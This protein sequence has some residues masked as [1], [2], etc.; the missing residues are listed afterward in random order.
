MILGDPRSNRS[1]LRLLAGRVVTNVGDSLYHIAAMWLIF[2]LTGSPLYTGIGGFL[3]TAPKALTFLTGP[4]VDRWPLRRVLVGTQLING[5]LVLAIPAAAWTGHLSV[6]IVLAAF[7]LVTFVNQFVYPAQNAAL[8]HIVEDDD[9]ARA[10][11]L[12]SAAYRGADM[13]FSAASGVL[14]AV[15]G[16][17]ALFLVDSVTFFVA[18]LLFAGLAVTAG[19]ED[20]TDPNQAAET[21]DQAAEATSRV[22]AEGATGDATRGEGDVTGDATRSDGYLAELREGFAYVRGSLLVGLLAGVVVGNVTAGAMFGVLPAF[23]AT[24]GGPDA[25]G[26][27]MAAFAGGSLVGTLAASRLSHLPFGRFVA[28]SNV[29]SGVLFAAVLALGWFPAIVGALFLSFVPAG[30]FTVLFWTMLQ[31]TVGEDLLGRVSSL[32]TSITTIAIPVGSAVGG[33]VA[34]V[35]GSRIVMFAWAAGSLFFG[36]Y[37]TARP[38]LRSLP[39]ASDVTAATLRVGTEADTADRA[40]ETA[41]GGTTGVTD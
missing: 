24:V 37:V 32:V 29:F 19:S 2:E 34:S 18:L 36:V 12:L 7:P 40:D 31:S 33:A 30:A 25:Y 41:P 3:V 22:D 39:P 4:L 14:V 38:A 15:V 11:S 9:L 6:W 23:A 5:L 35:V 26:F 1:F 13:V 28:V 10:N 17:V 8:P 21:T 16:A 20:V 27:L